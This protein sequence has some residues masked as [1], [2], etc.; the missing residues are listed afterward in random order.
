[1]RL[2]MRFVPESG[3]ADSAD[4]SASERVALNG[5]GIVPPSVE[6]G[7]GAGQAE[8]EVVDGDGKLL[9]R[10]PTLPDA[11]CAK[12][13]PDG[14]RVLVAGEGLGTALVSL[15]SEE[16]KPGDR[17]AGNYKGAALTACAIGNGAQAKVV[18]GTRDGIVLQ[19]AADGDGM[20]P[21]S[22]LAAF[23]LGSPALDVAIDG[24][25]RFV[26]VVGE[27]VSSKC[28]NGMSGHPLRIWDL[29]SSRPG[30]PVASTCLARAIEAIG[31][32]V[33][34]ASGWVLPVFERRGRERMRFD[35]RCLACEDDAGKAGM[36]KRLDA[37][38][39]AYS[40]RILSKPDTRRLYGFE[41]ADNG[42]FLGLEFR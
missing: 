16:S 23:R 6:A 41:K 30:F 27:R 17:S 9:L 31:P 8:L 28:L 35:Y 33:L 32:P 2:A 24:G 11:K 5:R 1:V 14:E 29:Q 7:V 25:S 10:R 40:P 3:P 20:R 15:L 13:S 22:E 18:L 21:V 12:V 42:S 38:A 26:A 34:E 19:A 4:A 39:M 37:A 36:R